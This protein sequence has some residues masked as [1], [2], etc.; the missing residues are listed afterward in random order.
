MDVGQP[1]HGARAVQVRGTGRGMVP[2]HLAPLQGPNEEW[3]QCCQGVLGPS[4]QPGREYGD[5]G[6]DGPAP[7]FGPVGPPRWPSLVQD[8][9]ECRLSANKGEINVYFQ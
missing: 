3:Q 7:T 6:G 4:P 2:S 8:L 5:G 1:V 9:A